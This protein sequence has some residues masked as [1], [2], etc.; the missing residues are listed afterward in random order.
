MI[1]ADPDAIVRSADGG[2]LRDRNR[3]AAERDG[4]RSDAAERERDRVAGAHGRDRI[5]QAPGA[6]VVERIRDDGIDA[7]GVDG[8]REWR[9][10]AAVVDSVAAVGRDDGARP[11]YERRQR[12]LPRRDR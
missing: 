6:A 1:A 12:A 7:A 10:W 4:V 9:A 8:M 3:R 5:A 11:G 2:V